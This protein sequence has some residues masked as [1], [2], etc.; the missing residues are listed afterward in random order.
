MRVH[1]RTHGHLDFAGLWRSR[2]GRAPAA[3]LG[4]RPC[5]SRSQPT[6]V[7]A[8]GSRR[9]T[10]RRSGSAR[11]PAAGAGRARCRCRVRGSPWRSGCA[12][13]C[14][15]RSRAGRRRHAPVAAT[16]PPRRCKPAGSAFQA[17]REAGSTPVAAPQ[18]A[19]APARA[20]RR[21]RRL[22]V[23][24]MLDA[25]SSLAALARPLRQAPVPSTAAAARELPRSAD[26][27]APSHRWRAGRAQLPS[28]SAAPPPAI[29]LAGGL[30]AVPHRPASGPAWSAGPSR[31]PRHAASGGA[32]LG[33][34][35]TRLAPRGEH[36]P[37]RGPSSPGERKARSRSNQQ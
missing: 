34:R 21:T 32:L 3:A 8:A 27:P 17:G 7:R 6:Q 37:R 18:P 33:D 26:Q 35:A 14:A 25:A 22:H 30:L 29:A 12:S 11:P 16:A 10:E 2:R 15:R 13:G 24:R 23:Q 28:A 20:A 4:C 31:L 36:G 5:R 1:A 9:R 19:A